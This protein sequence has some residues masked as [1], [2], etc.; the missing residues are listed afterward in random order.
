MKHFILT[1][2]LDT[3]IFHDD[4]L[5]KRFEIARRIYNALVSVTQKRYKEMIKT[6]M[7]RSIKKQLSEIYKSN[8][9]KLTIHEKR[10]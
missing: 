2:P 10:N 9:K 4:V 6:I 8:S 1:F 3:E 5:N 7:Y